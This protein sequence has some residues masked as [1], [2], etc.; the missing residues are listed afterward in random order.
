MREELFLPLGILAEPMDVSGLSMVGLQRL[1][2]HRGGV[3][4]DLLRF[5]G[6]CSPRAERDEGVWQSTSRFHAKRTVGA[7]CFQIT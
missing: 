1:A 7:G 2:D 4:P 3:R 5:D 6:H